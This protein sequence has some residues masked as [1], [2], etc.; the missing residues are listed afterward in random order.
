MESSTARYDCVSFV[1][2]LISE[3]GRFSKATFVK[4]KT[5]RTKVFQKAVTTAPKQQP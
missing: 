2:L 5:L 3:V 4:P 1:T